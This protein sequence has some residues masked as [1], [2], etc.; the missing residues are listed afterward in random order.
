M[1]DGVTSIDLEGVV[2]FANERM[3][4]LLGIPEEELVGQSLYSVMTLA[5]AEDLRERVEGE[6]QAGTTWTNEVELVCRGDSSL[7]VELH[8]S[9]LSDG[10]GRVTG[11]QLI[12]HDISERRRQERQLVRLASHDHL[13]GLHNRRFFEAATRGRARR[14]AAQR[15]AGARALARRR[16]LQGRQRHPRAP[17]RATRSSSRV[18]EQLRKQVRESNVLARLGGDEFARPDPGDATRRKRPRPRRASSPR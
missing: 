18:A 17:R 4:V 3:C 2:T 14:G 7:P 12:A 10:A 16:R 13:T 15:Q 9:A 6:I 5:S 11:A 1:A 8:A